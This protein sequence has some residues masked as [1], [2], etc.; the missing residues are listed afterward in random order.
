MEFV[1]LIFL[2]I[3]AGYWVLLRR[4]FLKEYFEEIDDHP[5][6][7]QLEFRTVPPAESISKFYKD[8]HSKLL[9]RKNNLVS[10]EYFPDRRQGQFLLGCDREEQQSIGQLLTDNFAGIMYKEIKDYFPVLLKATQEKA[11]L[12][13]ELELP[14]FIPLKFNDSSDIFSL[15]SKIEGVYPQLIIRPVPSEW[16]STAGVE[17]EESPRRFSLAEKSLIDAKL[18][19][20]GYQFSLRVVVTA[21]TEAEAKETFNTIRRGVRSSVSTELNNLIARNRETS[22]L[23]KV[24]QRFV[25][26][27]LSEQL[28]G[29][30]KFEARFLDD[31]TENVLAISELTGISKLE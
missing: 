22:M 26:Q 14:F 1:I 18:T 17:R 2:L 7:L 28:D 23:T 5:V 10:L 6:F 21:K 27:N 24:R 19:Q 4:E 15:F 29:F 12:E 3:G 20:A 11:L 16:Q 8:L 25:A 9:G 30:E 13:F 31:D